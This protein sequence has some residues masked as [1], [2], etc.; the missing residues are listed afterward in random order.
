M[1][2]RIGTQELT[3]QLEARQGGEFEEKSFE[4]F[5]PI[6]DEIFLVGSD[7]KMFCGPVNWK[8]ENDESYLIIDEERRMARL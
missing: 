5:F 4:K 3:L 2:D 6:A 8:I 7:P 1:V